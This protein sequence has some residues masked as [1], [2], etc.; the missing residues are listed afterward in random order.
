LL[1]HLSR[2]GLDYWSDGLFHVQGCESDEANGCPGQA[3][4][5][6]SEESCAE[7]F[8][9][10]AMI[11][12]GSRWWSATHDVG[13]KSHGNALND[14]STDRS[15]SAT[16]L[17]LFFRGRTERSLFFERKVGRR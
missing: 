12:P 2:D 16:A 15:L 10:L 17:A 8:F 4:T 14:L 5:H 7:S 6:A 9:R 3:Q 11:R 1:D 13:L